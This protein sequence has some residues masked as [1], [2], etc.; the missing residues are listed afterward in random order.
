MATS[1]LT[2]RPS[3][4][5]STGKKLLASAAIIGTAAAVAGLGTFGE[6]VSSTNASQ[7]VT[8]GSAGL[9][10]PYSTMDKPISGMLPGDSI[11][12]YATLNN[13]GTESLKGVYLVTAVAEPNLLTTDEANGLRIKIVNCAVPWTVVTG[14]ADVCTS[15][16][17]TQ[18]ETVPL[19]T[20]LAGG[21]QAL[22]AM[23]SMTGGGEDHL[24]AII[25]LPVTADTN[26]A[27][28]STTIDFTFTGVQRD[29]MLLE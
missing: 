29:G 13:P 20:F 25:S 9:A 3:K 4:N 14:G 2:D 7:T 23:Q 18:V 19:A 5:S 26:F 10:M 12:R 8:S 11:E 16:E 22:P 21:E 6:F 17:T 1:T 28:I 27:K 15:K 24:K